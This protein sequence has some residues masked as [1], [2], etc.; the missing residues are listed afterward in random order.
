MKC[1]N[2]NCRRSNCLYSAEPRASLM[3]EISFN[4]ISA[5]NFTT[6]VVINF[7]SD[8]YMFSFR[9]KGIGATPP[10]DKPIEVIFILLRYDENC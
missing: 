3:G 10:A 8:N 2:I 4:A 6:V 7:H 1:A 9:Y 5:A